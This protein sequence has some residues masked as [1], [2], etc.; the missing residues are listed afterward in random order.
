MFFCYLSSDFR[1]IAVFIDFIVEKK[2]RKCKVDFYLIF[3]CLLK[4]IL[5][6]CAT[7]TFY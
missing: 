6:I 2:V 3:N 1:T 7:A 5:Y 4:T